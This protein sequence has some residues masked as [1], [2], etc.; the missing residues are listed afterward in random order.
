LDK[1]EL[2][3]YPANTINEL[4]EKFGDQS[5]I[6]VIHCFCRQ[7][8]KFVDEPCR[9]HGIGESCVAIGDIAAHA[10]EVGIGRFISKENALELIQDLQKKGAIHQIFH[11]KDDIDKPEVAICNCCWDCCAIFG[12]YNRGL[13]PLRLKSYYKAQISD[14]TLCTGCGTCVKY[15][16]TWAISVVDKKSQIDAKK[17]IGCGQCE[18]QCP[19]EVI[20]LVHE[21]RDV[22]LPLRK[23]SEA[24]ISS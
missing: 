1:S 23:K 19:E 8:K 9:F 3:V 10:V 22:M 16:P 24:R 14:G 18:L 7:W 12:S 21:E 2:R 4:I 5:K 15:C 20:S 6:A 13:L 11:T 17:C